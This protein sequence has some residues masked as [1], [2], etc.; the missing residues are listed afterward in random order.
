MYLMMDS[1]LPV[2]TRIYPAGL[3][4]QR[5]DKERSMSA[6]NN[7]R[8]PGVRK[9]T[10]SLGEVDVPNGKLWGAQ[11]QPSVA[12]I[13]KDLIS[14]EALERIQRHRRFFHCSSQC[15]VALPGSRRT[16]GAVESRL[17]GFRVLLAF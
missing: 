14:R 10:D 8:V 9:E 4:A 17:K 2:A 6:T 5:E 12:N 15:G 16:P 11:T 7:V 3:I 1:F 13:W